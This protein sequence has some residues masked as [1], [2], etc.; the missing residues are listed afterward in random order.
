[1]KRCTSCQ[2]HLLVHEPSCPFCGVAQGS[3]PRAPSMAWVLV[4]GLATASCIEPAPPVD[5]GSNGSSDVGGSTSSGDSTSA[6]SITATATTSPSTTV[7][8][9]TMDPSGDTNITDTQGNS[10][11]LYGGFDAGMAI[12]CD[13]YAQDCPVGEKCMPWANDG[14]DQW[15]ATRCS[16]IDDDPGQPGEECTVEGSGTSGIDDCDLGAMCWDVDPATNM[17]T[18]VAM[19]MGDEENPTCEDRNTTCEISNDGV[20][21]LCLPTCDPLAQS[22]PEGEACYPSQDAWV[23]RP[24]GSGEMGGYGDPCEA[25]DG[26]D[27]G[28]VCLASE[29]VPPGQPCEGEAGCC[30]EVCDLTDAAGDAQC[31]GA[32][33][34]QTCQAWYDDPPPGY[35][36]VGVCA[37]PL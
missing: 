29:V 37:L 35:E 36:N 22:C 20:L 2:R 23:C 26:C 18:C 16:P 11:L 34:G 30:T 21:V 8:D 32:P 10:F 3:L 9:D 14:G 13:V 27:P 19:C 15:N 7:V 12:E 1:M 5:D 24:D 33:G 25:I 17:G 31:T 6:A 28:L 4:L